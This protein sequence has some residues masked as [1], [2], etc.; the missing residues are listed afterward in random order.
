MTAVIESTETSLLD[1]LDFQPACQARWCRQD[2]PPATHRYQCLVPCHPVDMFICADCTRLQLS[3]FTSEMQRR[4]Q[5][6][7]FHCTACD[8]EW[9][10]SRTSWAFTPLPGGQ[11]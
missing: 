2:H 6:A 5:Q 3:S 7:R 9:L 10:M 4:G 1:A 11:Q 8:A